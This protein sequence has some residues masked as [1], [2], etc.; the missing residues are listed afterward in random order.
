MV[1]LL[2]ACSVDIVS[3]GGGGQRQLFHTKTK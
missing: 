3:A 1:S 2:A